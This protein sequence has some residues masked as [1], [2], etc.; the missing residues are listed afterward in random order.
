MQFAF[1]PLFNMAS[2]SPQGNGLA[3]H[4]QSSTGFLMSQDLFSNR[5]TSSAMAHLDQV[6][7]QPFRSSDQTEEYYA[8]QHSTRGGFANNVGLGDDASQFKANGDSFMDPNAT[9]GVH[10]QAPVFDGGPEFEYASPSSMSIHHLESNGEYGNDHQV[11]ATA[12]VSADD[13]RLALKR[14]MSTRN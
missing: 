1:T 6:N 3:H 13:A 4:Q 10:P 5:P 14:V 12:H 9:K 11:R 7:D 8:D 2:T